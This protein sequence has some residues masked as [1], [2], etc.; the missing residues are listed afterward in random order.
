MTPTFNS[1]PTRRAHSPC[2]LV[3]NARLRT[4]RQVLRLSSSKPILSSKQNLRFLLVLMVSCLFVAQGRPSFPSVTKPL[5]HHL[6]TSLAGVIETLQYAEEKRVSLEK[7][8][9]GLVSGGMCSSYHKYYDCSNT[10]LA[11]LIRKHW[12]RPSK[13]SLSTFVRSLPRKRV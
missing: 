8:L 9:E 2:L 4:L 6:P 12:P 3:E 11:Q 1:S 10:R 13:L 5:R 7:D